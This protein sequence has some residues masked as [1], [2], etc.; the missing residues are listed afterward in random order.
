MFDGK[1]LLKKAEGLN[2]FAGGD[3][4]EK[5]EK[6]QKCLEKHGISKEKSKDIVKE[7]AA[8]FIEK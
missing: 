2:I 5:I 7:L 3:L 1:D 4:K 8:I 6:A